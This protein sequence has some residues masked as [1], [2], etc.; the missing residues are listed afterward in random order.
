[1]ARKEGIDDLAAIFQP[2]ELTRA[3]CTPVKTNLC[4][5]Q[6][7]VYMYNISSQATPLPRRLRLLDH[8]AAPRHLVQID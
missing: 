1:M 8:I 5:D 4:P 6:T 7:C 2:S 3:A